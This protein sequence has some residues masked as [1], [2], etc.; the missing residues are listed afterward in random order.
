[1]EVK[2]GQQIQVTLTAVDAEGNPIEV[3]NQELTFTVVPGPAQNFT[4]ALDE[5]EK[6]VKVA[7]N[8][9]RSIELEE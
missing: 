2:A 3:L 5:E 1:M 4:V 8:P 7:K 9:S 6:K